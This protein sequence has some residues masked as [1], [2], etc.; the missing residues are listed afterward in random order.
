MYIVNFKVNYDSTSLICTLLVMPLHSCSSD[1][2]DDDEMFDNNW[3]NQM[4]FL[5]HHITT[6]EAIK[7]YL[8]NLKITYLVTSSPSFFPTFIIIP[9]VMLKTEAKNLYTFL[10]TWLY[11]VQ[12][13]FKFRL[14]KPI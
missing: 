14:K 6:V 10:Q 3:K 13:K 9:W 7:D 4:I 2:T 12:I 5:L 11:S 1:D 8:T